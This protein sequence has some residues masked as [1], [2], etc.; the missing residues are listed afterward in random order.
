[1]TAKYLF[2]LFFKN[3]KKVRKSQFFRAKFHF[4]SY[5]QK[6]PIDDK[7]ML[8]EAFSGDDFS[9]N[10]FYVFEYIYNNK[11][12][13]DYR[14]IISVNKAS[15]EKVQQLLDK[16]GYTENVKI[17]QKNS[18]QYC[19]ALTTAKYLVNNVAFPTYFI[20]RDEQVYLNTWHGTPLKGLGRS[21]KDNPNSIGNVQRNFLM[22]NYLLYP[23]KY[24]FE[25]IKP[26]LYR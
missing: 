22:C 16:Y 10:P 7:L 20:K 3:L 8:F 1:M 12:F 13:D 21:I 5:S 2:N 9:G 19:K 17:L 24:S 6:Y 26:V 15:V 25:H 18:H 4:T 14:K 11:E 23:N